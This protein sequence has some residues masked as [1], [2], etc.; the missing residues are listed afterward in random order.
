MYYCISC[1]NEIPEENK[2][3]CPYCGFIRSS[4]LPDEGTLQPETWFENRYYIGKAYRTDAGGASY[5]VYDR[6]MG[7]KAVLRQLNAGNAGYGDGLAGVEP[8]FRLYER[9]ERFLHTY[10]KLAGLEISSL[11]LV[12]TCKAQDRGA[13][14]VSEYISETTL[15]AYIAQSGGKTFE[16]A[17][18]L[19]LPVIVALKL[20]HDRGICHGA[21]EPRC[22]R[23]T[24]KTLVLCDADGTVPPAGAENDPVKADIRAFLQIF[25]AMMYGSPQMAEPD[26]FTAEYSRQNE[27][28]LPDDV[29]HYLY[30]VFN[31][32][33]DIAVTADRVLEVFYHSGDVAVLPPRPVHTVPA[34]FAEAAEQAGVTL[35]QVLTSLV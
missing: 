34:C 5:V 18:H 8:N 3:Q 17:C 23:K 24:D 27:L 30:D 29:M 25:V 19:M 35:S 10:R 13:Y 9:R 15:E 21:L 7:R 11:P 26:M 28:K 14:A 16:G 33:P 4:Y 2:D 32:T 22:I 1:L 12:Y 20:M 6:M 31:H